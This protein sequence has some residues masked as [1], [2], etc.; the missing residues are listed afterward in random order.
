MNTHY[1]NS[2][3][4]ELGEPKWERT[5]K[6]MCMC[7][8][9]QVTPYFWKLNFYTRTE[10]LI[11][12]CHWKQVTPYFFGKKLLEKIENLHKNGQINMYVSLKTSNSVQ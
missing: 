9:K 2:T 11:C 5:D 1:K 8:R 12:M 4:C 3:R 7:H 6:L 10:K